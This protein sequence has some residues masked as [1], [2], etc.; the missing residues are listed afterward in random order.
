MMKKILFLSICILS[1][2]STLASASNYRMINSDYILNANQID[3]KFSK[4]V[5]K[6][7]AVVSFKNCALCP[8]ESFSI[9]ANSDLYLQH[10]ATNFSKFKQ[11][12]MSDK[13]QYNKNSNKVLISLDSRAGKDQVFSIKWNYTEL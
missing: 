11:Q 1:L 3:I 4:S 5:Y 7:E 12:V 8:S 2:L 6:E 10:L 9:N 13:A